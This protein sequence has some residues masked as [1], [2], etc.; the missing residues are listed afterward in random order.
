MP[1]VPSELQEL[2]VKYLDEMLEVG[3]ALHVAQCAVAPIVNHLPSVGSTSDLPV[4]KQTLRGYRKA[5]P[6]RSR[7]PICKEIMAGIGSH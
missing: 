4:V 3:N 2:F 6:P 7:A 5:K 1:S